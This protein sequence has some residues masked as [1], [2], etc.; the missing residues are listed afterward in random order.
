[1]ITQAT[2]DFLVKSNKSYLMNLFLWYKLPAAYW[3]GVRLV[4]V[5]ENQAVAKVPYKRMSQN[6]FGSTYFACLSMAAELSTGILSLA[7]IQG[8]NPSI[9]MLVSKVN[10][11]YLK[12]ATEDT[13]FY[14][15]DGQKVFE[16]V[17]KARTTGEAVEIMLK[18]VGKNAK[19]VEIARFEITWSFKARK[20]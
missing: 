2:K 15:E 5:T 9:S 14:C 19:G 11:E 7:A 17:E 1:M 3:A 12:K 4:S 13:F 10:S 6:P 18:S 8:A 20:A 16:S